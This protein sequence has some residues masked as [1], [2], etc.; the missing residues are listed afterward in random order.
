MLKDEFEDVLDVVSVQA[1]R[2]EVGRGGKSAAVD[3]LVQFHGQLLA[4]VH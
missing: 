1:G 4:F 3:V 2:L